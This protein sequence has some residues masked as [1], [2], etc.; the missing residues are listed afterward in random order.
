MLNTLL[1]WTSKQ[2]FFTENDSTKK[3][4]PKWEKSLKHKMRCRQLFLSSSLSRCS[5][6]RD[7]WG[8]EFQTK[9]QQ[10]HQKRDQCEKLHWK[11]KLMATQ[12]WKILSRSCKFPGVAVFCSFL[13]NAWGCASWKWKLQE[14]RNL[15]PMHHINQF[16]GLKLMPSKIQRELLT[17][18][19][20]TNATM[21][22]WTPLESPKPVGS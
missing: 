14:V 6:N 11:T 7:Y 12:R 13:A 18:R 21:S 17:S 2:I 8:I 20:S 10:Q 9:T 16:V 22:W 4:E 15:P 5:W 1:N 3:G 19:Q